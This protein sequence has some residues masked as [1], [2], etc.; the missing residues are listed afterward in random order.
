[1]K[2]KFQALN[3][4][5]RTFVISFIV[6]L[7]LFILMIPF[8]FFNLG[9]IS[10]GLILGEFVSYLFCFIMGFIDK[11]RPDSKK[12]SAFLITALIMRLLILALV[13]VVAAYLYYKLNHHIFNVFAIIGG[14]F[15][16][17]AILI[18][19]LIKERKE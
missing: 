14:Y 11:T 5:H 4:F 8:L 10:F 1:M 7:G 13:S 17:L 6:S 16:P 3:V 18:I 2:E 15:I 12:S 9:E 19:N